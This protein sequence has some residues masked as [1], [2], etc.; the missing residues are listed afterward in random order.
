MGRF[1]KYWTFKYD[2]DRNAETVSFVGVDL[3]GL[4]LHYNRY[5]NGIQGNE[6]IIVNDTNGRIFIGG[7]I[8]EDR[9]YGGVDLNVIGADLV[10]VHHKYGINAVGGVVKNMG[11]IEVERDFS[12]VIDEHNNIV[13]IYLI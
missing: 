3:I 6:S 11:T 9:D 10:G 4:G 8:L 1:I 12:K 13:D 2:R 7:D 5:T